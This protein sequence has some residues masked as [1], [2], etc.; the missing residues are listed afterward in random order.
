MQY[1]YLCLVP[2]RVVSRESAVSVR[3]GGVAELECVAHGH[4]EPSIVWTRAT[5]QGQVS[6]LT[7]NS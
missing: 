3:A 5:Q 6:S 2:P 4:P 7:S 1:K